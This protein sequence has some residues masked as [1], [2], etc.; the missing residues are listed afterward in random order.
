MFKALVSQFQYL[1]HLESNFYFPICFDL[2]FLFQ[3]RVFF[4]KS[5]LIIFK[6]F[7]MLGMKILVTPDDFTSSKKNSPY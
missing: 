1:D 6:E 2:F 3:L 5:Y 7:Q 4:K